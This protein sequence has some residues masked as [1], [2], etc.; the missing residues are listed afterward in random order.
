L[1]FSF[2]IFLFEFEILFFDSEFFNLNLKKLFDSKVEL[3]IANYYFA[4][5]K[6]MFQFKRLLIES[7][8][9]HFWILLF[10]LEN[11]HFNS[12]ICY[13]T[14]KNVFDLKFDIWIVN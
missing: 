8:N 14:S 13:L 5:S 3:W 7:K 11:W 9:E 4:F 6:L 12:E 1:T 10:E 2:W